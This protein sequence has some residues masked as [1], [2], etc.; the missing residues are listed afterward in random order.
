M[1]DFNSSL[2]V[3]TENAGDV[4]VKVADA[5]VPSQQLAVNADGSLNI[6]DNNG[7]LTVDATDL[8]IRDINS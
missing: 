8:D 3:R 1:S 6:T 7:S 5:L 4:I 2:P